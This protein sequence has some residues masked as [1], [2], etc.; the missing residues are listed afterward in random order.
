[1]RRTRVRDDERPAGLGSHWRADGTT[2]T[3]YMSR[4]EAHSVAEE[5]R[6][7]VGVELDVYRCSTCS[8]WHLGRPVERDG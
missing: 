8:A 1:M 5:R 4:G 7:E 6:H 2:K 3:S